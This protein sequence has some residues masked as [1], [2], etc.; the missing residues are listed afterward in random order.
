MWSIIDASVVVLPEPV[1]P[2][3]ST[4]P[5]CSSASRLTP[6]GRLSCSKLGTSRG[7]TRKANEM[8]PRWR[9]ALTRKR[10]RPSAV[11][12]MS[13]SPVSWNVFS[14][15]GVTP[16]HG[17]ECAEQVLL[18]QRRALVERRDRTVA[19]QHRRL[20]QLE[21]DV[22]R[23]EFNGAPEEGIQVHRASRE[24]SAGSVPCF[25]AARAG[26]A[27]AGPIR[28]RPSDERRRRRRVRQ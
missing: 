9:K 14:R 15:S 4:R 26:A 28:A 1:A 20:V 27:A 10:G 23:A 2:V 3:K 7:M 12:A 13:R 19:T 17:L 24:E 11:Y 5:R 21:V 25:R 8:L 16:S 22:A 18:G 6:A